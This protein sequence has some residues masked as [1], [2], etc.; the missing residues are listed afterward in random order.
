MVWIDN[1]K[2]YDMVPQSC[3]KMYKIF[4]KVIKFIKNTM[5]NWRVKMTAE[6]KSLPEV[7][8]QGGIFQGDAQSPLLFVIAMM[9]LNNLLRECTGGYKLNKSPEKINHL[10]YMDDIKLFAK[11]EKELESLIKAVRIYSQDIGMEFAIEKCAVLIMKSGRQHR[12]EGMELPNQEKI[13]MLGKSKHSNT[14]EYWKRTP[15]NIWK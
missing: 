5:K 15:L 12:T 6:R 14:W 3:L 8:I 2:A 4:S 11:N 1:K 7:K 13:R 10:M 9:P